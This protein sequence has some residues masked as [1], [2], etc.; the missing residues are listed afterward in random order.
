MVV[1]YRRAKRKGAVKGA[2]PGG[3]P[4]I[5]CKTQKIF[6]RDFKA[7]KKIFAIALALVMVLSMASAFAAATM[8]GTCS[9]GSWDCTTYTSKC[10]VAKAEVVLFVKGNNCYDTYSA[11]NCAGVVKG[12]HLFYGVKVTFDKDVNKQWFNHNMTTLYITYTDMNNGYSTNPDLGPAKAKI[13]EWIG[14]IVNYD[15]VKNGGTFWFDFINKKLVKEDDFNDNCVDDG[16]AKT[17]KAKVC[18][19]VTYKFDGL[20][21]NLQKFRTNEVMDEGWIDFGQ[22]LVGSFADHITVRDRSDNV[23]TFNIEKNK[24]VSI[25]IDGKVYNAYKDGKL[26]GVKFDGQGGFEWVTDGTACS[27]LPD[28]LKF[29]GISDLGTCMTGDAIKAH[30]GWD[31]DGAF[32]SCKTWSKNAVVA[33]DPECKVEIPKTGDV[34]VV[35]YA[36]MALV[37]AAGAMGLKK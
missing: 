22:Y 1:T 23:A 25:E 13:S 4:P 7:M 34:S 28:M 8:P 18:A 35:A 31:D 37:A 16:W 33:V 26:Y 29:L 5:T 9:F 3:K 6:E 24:L 36:V 20:S 12:E 21:V 30:F 19:N 32:K 17:T 11:S 14:D 27:F 15:D 2:S 10:G